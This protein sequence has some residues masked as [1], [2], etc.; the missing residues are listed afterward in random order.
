MALRSAW[1]GFLKLSLIAMPVRAYNS[2]ARDRGEIRFH[3]VH[4]GCG[5]RVQYRKFCPTHGELTKE[6]VVSGYEVDKGEFIELEREELTELKAEDDE[7]IN[8][9]AFADPASVDPVYFSGKT[10]YLV[11]AG[12]AGQKPYALLTRVMA[13]KGVVGLGQMVLSGHEE[14]VIIRPAGKLLSM[15]VLY[16]QSQ[17]KEP[18]TFES[19][20]ADPKVSPQEHRL[21]AALVD[22]SPVEAF[23]L[24]E[25]KDRYTERVA[26][27]I[28]G[29]T[30]GRKPRAKRKGKHPA[31][32][33]L[34]DALKKSLDEAKGKRPA[35]PRRKR[36]G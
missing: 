21:A 4:K 22:E 36:T 1:E 7:E 11:P 33:N 18:G 13:E 30:S 6:D 29:K 24:S 26:A 20:V 19:E 31:V 3:Q 8:L 9:T 15:T 2:A 34:M 17:V 27:F 35:A 25:M 10:F 5:Q 16:Y 23:D 28:E 12:A 32:I 14:A